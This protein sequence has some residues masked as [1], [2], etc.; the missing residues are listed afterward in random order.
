MLVGGTLARPPCQSKIGS[1]VRDRCQV[2]VTGR[3]FCTS[4]IQREVI[5]AH[6]QIGSNQKSTRVG[7]CFVSSYGV[8]H[9]F[10]DGEPPQIP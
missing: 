1:R 4:R 10:S 8:M 6:G 7:S 5:Q 2:T 9:T 3:T